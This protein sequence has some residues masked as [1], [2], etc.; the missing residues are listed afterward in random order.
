[1]LKI[2]AVPSNTFLKIERRKLV[3]GRGSIEEN[4]RCGKSISADIGLPLSSL[5]AV[6]VSVVWISTLPG[7]M[8]RK[9]SVVG[10]P[11]YPVTLGYSTVTE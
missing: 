7:L 3:F 10:P 9:K 8:A 5:L 4:Y 6:P 2:T 1:M 11:V